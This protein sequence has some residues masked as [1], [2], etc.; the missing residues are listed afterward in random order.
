MTQVI[1]KRISEQLY[2]PLTKPG[3][4]LIHFGTS[5]FQKVS[6]GGNYSHLEKSPK[7]VCSFYNYLLGA[8]CIPA[9]Y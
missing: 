6:Q 3:R 1:R 2:V 7:W 9:V 8:F 5:S 4:G